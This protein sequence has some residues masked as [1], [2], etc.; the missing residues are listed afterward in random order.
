MVAN[1]RMLKIIARG[2][3]GQA[4]GLGLFAG[5]F[6]LLFTGFHDSSVA[7]GVLGGAMIPLG[8]WVM[9]L[10]RRGPRRTTAAPDQDQEGAD[11]D[12]LS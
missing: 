1:T 11:V 9:A 7:L 10:V 4:L 3:L 8:M 2:L 6:W 12:T 5:G